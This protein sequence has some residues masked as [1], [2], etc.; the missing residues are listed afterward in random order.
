MVNDYNTV[1][2]LIIHIIVE[3]Y[4][5]NRIYA[6]LI[7]LIDGLTLIEHPGWCSIRC[8]GWPPTS[9]HS[10]CPRGNCLL[11]T[12]YTVRKK[13]RRGTVSQ[14]TQQTQGAGEQDCMG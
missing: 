6:V 12:L 10:Y 4:Y 8:D 7:M 14:K 13:Y 9:E 1:S 2:I 11:H 5:V 3:P